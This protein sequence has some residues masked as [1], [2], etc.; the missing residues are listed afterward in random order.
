[1]LGAVESGVDFEKRI[2]SIY[3]RCRTPEQIAQEFDQLQQELDA[4]IAE[5]KRE[6]P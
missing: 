1:M 4:E 6:R 2:A 5:G 3:A